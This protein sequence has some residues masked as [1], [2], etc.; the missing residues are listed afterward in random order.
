MAG[1][2]ARMFAVLF[3]VGVSLTAFV[4]C[5]ALATDV[6]APGV[7]ADGHA[8]GE[9]EGH[10]KGN[11]APVSHC[12]Y[13]IALNV[14]AAVDIAQSAPPKSSPA[15]AP[16]AFVL[17]AWNPPV[18]VLSAASHDVRRQSGSPYRVVFAQTGRMLI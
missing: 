2:I 1:I 9:N 11:D 3:A 7:S 4:P 17:V 18:A 14:V 8:H 5:P 16:V 12:A 10:G 6:A 13:Q 15:F